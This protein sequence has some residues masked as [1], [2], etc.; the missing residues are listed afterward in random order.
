VGAQH[1]RN[2]PVIIKGRGST[3]RTMDALLIFLNKKFPF[4]FIEFH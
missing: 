4:F 1:R 3:P 2:G